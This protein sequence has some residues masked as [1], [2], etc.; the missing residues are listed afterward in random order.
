M[1]ICY[2]LLSWIL[3]QWKLYW[4]KMWTFRCISA[5]TRTQV[6]IRIPSCCQCA[7]GCRPRVNRTT[8]RRSIRAATSRSRSRETQIS[9]SLWSARA[10]AQKAIP[11]PLTSKFTRLSYTRS[12]SV[13]RYK[14]RAFTFSPA[15][16][17]SAGLSWRWTSSPRTSSFISPGSTSGSCMAKQEIKMSTSCK[18]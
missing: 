12:L 17:L 3:R 1:P 15:R 18:K 13:A 7:T 11:K 6:S 16:S 9:T 10:T 2:L 14:I 4:R 8:W 5:S